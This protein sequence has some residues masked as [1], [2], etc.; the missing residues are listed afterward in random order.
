VARGVGSLSAGHS[1]AKDSAHMADWGPNWCCCRRH[2]NAWQTRAR[3]S[4][5]WNPNCGQVFI[6]TPRVLDCTK[7]GSNESSFVMAE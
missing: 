5:A 3:T 7:Y 6:G 1:A 4:R 2:R